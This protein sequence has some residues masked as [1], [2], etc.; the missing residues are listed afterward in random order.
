M[1]DALQIECR[2]L[3]GLQ[4]Q[5]CSVLIN[6]ESGKLYYLELITKTLRYTKFIQGM[7]IHL[8][9]LTKMNMKRVFWLAA[10]LLLVCVN[11]YSQAS[12]KKMKQTVHS[13]AVSSNKKKSPSTKSS[14]T[15]ILN[16]ISSH[17]AKANTNTLSASQKK[18]AIA[19]PILTSLNARAIGENI[20]FNKSAIVG[21]PKHAYGFAN[22]H[23]TLHTTGA[24]TAGTET[25]S[26]GVG[27]GSSLATYG[28]IGAPMNVNGKSPFAGINMWGNALNMIIA[29]TDSLPQGSQIKNH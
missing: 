23:I 19:D 11:V 15:V 5:R 20:Q 16:T 4:K 7:A 8:Q 22:G 9:Y 3:I 26:G 28:S 2:L 12:P 25:G 6:E 1:E 27:T 24:V 17:P 18:Y 14:P 21:M 13:K 10:V 29:K